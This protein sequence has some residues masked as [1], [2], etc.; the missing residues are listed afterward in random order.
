MILPMRYILFLDGADGRSY[1][2]SMLF[3]MVER[4]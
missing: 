1:W 3:V 4:L 2:M